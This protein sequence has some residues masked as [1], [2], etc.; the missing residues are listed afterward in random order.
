MYTDVTLKADDFKAIHNALWSLQYGNGDLNAQVEV[1]RM[2]LEGAY[3]QDA[4]AANDLYDHYKSV[5]QINNLD[6][7]WSIQS[8]KDLNKPHPYKD[9]KTVTYKSYQHCGDEDVVV[10]IVGP[11][12]ASLYAAAD[13][14]IKQSGDEHHCF[15][16][17]FEQVGDTLMLVTGS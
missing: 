3:E 17:G 5:Q 6:A 16:E 8:V 15:I 7:I 13:T 4:K 11:W 9:A 14:A 2:A 12:W 10:P 1:I